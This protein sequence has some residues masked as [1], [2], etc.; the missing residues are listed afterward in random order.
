MN[1]N[2]IELPAHYNGIGMHDSPGC[3]VAAW[4]YDTSRARAGELRAMGITADKLFETG[5]NKV[6]RCRG[7]VDGGLLV[8]VRSWVKQPFGRGHYGW[9]TPGDQIRAYVDAGAQLFEPGPNEFN[10]AAEWVGNKIPYDPAKIAVEVVNIWEVM[11]GRQAEAPGSHMLFPANT[12]GGNV[13]HRLCYQ[14]IRAELVRRGL[15][16]TVEHVAIHPRPLN[17]PP[18]VTWTPANTCTFDEWRW[19]RDCLGAD[20]F[21]W[22][23]EHGYAVNDSQNH[24]YPPMNLQTWTDWNRELQV[25]M[26]PAHAAAFEPQLAGTFHWI[27]ALWGHRISWFQDSLRDA[28]VPEMPT[29]SPLWVL[30]GE[31]PAP[32]AFERYG[33]EPEPPDP[34]D[35]PGIVEGIDISWYQRSGMDWEQAEA[36]GIR[37]AYIRASYG[38]SLDAAV[39]GHTDQALYH[40]PGIRLGYYHYLDPNYNATTQGRFFAALCLS[41]AGYEPPAVDVEAACVT[42]QDV[43]DF[44]AAFEAAYG[45]PGRIYTRAQFWNVLGDLSDIAA[46]WGLWVAHW[47]VDKP[48]LPN[49]WT[50]WQVWQY[51]VKRD[52]IHPGRVDRDRMKVEGEEPPDPPDPPD[53]VQI[54][55]KDGQLRDWDW[56]T[57]EFGL[58]PA[59]VEQG[60]Q[61]HV[62][63]IQEGGSEAAIVVYAPPGTVVAFGWPDGYTEATVEPKGEL[64][65]SMGPGAYYW[66][67]AVGPHY[68]QVGDVFMDG[69]GMIGGTNHRHVNIT[70]SDT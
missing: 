11:L 14:A 29:P 22:A 58:T 23:T 66:P 34:P 3:G 44:C 16:G 46:D 24:D 31:Q 70:V 68:I 32:L 15:L 52:G 48:T 57:L 59:E 28:H 2:G 37:L 26:N 43:R 40:V 12:P 63:R 39:F 33:G 49:G 7:E 41:L 51:T 21:Y 19:I 61:W 5:G 17:N 45:E 47:D 60:T 38:L 30:M 10:I 67:P 25:R 65:F 54:L 62:T 13:D 56:L 9:V 53:S 20:K 42:G 64:G 1:L 4:D 69:L 36:Q 18:W 8:M 55:D 50:D 27:E 6:Q 35:P